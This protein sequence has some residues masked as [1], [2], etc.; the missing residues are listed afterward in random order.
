MAIYELESG[1]MKTVLFNTRTYR[2]KRP[3][4]PQ[5]LVE[6]CG[7]APFRRNLDPAASEEAAP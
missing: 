5:A 7:N 6:V 1:G 2:G 4:V 3:P